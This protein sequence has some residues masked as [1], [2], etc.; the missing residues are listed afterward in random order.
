MH[1]AESTCRICGSRG[2]FVRLIGPTPH[3]WALRRCRRCRTLLRTFT[4]DS[5]P[6]YEDYDT[7]AAYG[8]AAATAD[9][10]YDRLRQAIDA[11]GRFSPDHLS[12]LDIACGDG[13]LLNRF[14]RSHSQARILGID[15]SVQAVERAREVYGVPVIQ[16]YFGPVLPAPGERFAVISVFGAFSIFP[17]PVGSLRQMADLL[18]PGGILVVEA[19]NVDCLIRRMS[20]WANRLFPVNRL[21]IINRLNHICW[22]QVDVGLSRRQFVQVGQEIGLELCEITSAPPRL[23]VPEVT[24]VR[25]QGL[26]ANVIRC[27]DFVDTWTENR[28]W[29]TFVYRKP[30]A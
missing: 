6:H 30:V 7:T 26:S 18:F 4:D 19:I 14:R 27:C 2:P 5:V 21:N 28:G 24:R 3:G 13:T 11:H 1:I 20:L 22:R 10:L 29:L 23:L 17:D 15:T 25:S 12:L 16:G 8:D 9:Y